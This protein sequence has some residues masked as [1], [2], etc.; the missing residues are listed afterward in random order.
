MM[1][2][3]TMGFSR[4]MTN[5]FET[6][7]VFDTETTDLVQHKLV[8]LERQPHVIEFGA[9]LGKLDENGNATE[10]AT[11]DFLCHPGFEI[12]DLTT[13]LTGIT[14]AMLADQP[15]IRTRLD[16]ITSFFA[17]AETRAGHNL[18]FDESMLNFEFQRASIGQPQPLSWQPA[19]RQ[20]RI[21]TVE[22]TDHLKGFRLN[23]SKLHELLFN[24]PFT[25]AHR[26]LV[27][28]RAT[29]RCIAELRRR[30]VI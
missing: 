21:C 1:T 12:Q 13:T 17:R 27:D 20:R 18:T 10:I 26:A 4:D 22:T 9:L 16:A 29:W 3:I 5:G 6:V 15:H 24:E 14:R 30:K 11:L 23:L 2:M 25:D 8:P 28:V 19:R 7:I